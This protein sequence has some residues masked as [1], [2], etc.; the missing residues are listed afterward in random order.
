MMEANIPPMCVS[1]SLEPD[2][3]KWYT[4]IEQPSPTIGLVGCNDYHR[5]VIQVLEKCRKQNQGDLAVNFYPLDH[6]DLIRKKREN[7]GPVE[8]SAP[9]GLLKS[10]WCKR[11]QT[12]IFGC[13]IV[14][15]KIDDFSSRE[16]FETG[17]EAIISKVQYRLRGR[18]TKLLVVIIT[19]KDRPPFYERPESCP[20][21]I[22]KRCD[23]EA[24][25]NVTL[26]YLGGKNTSDPIKKILQTAQDFSL[27]Y[28]KEECRRIKRFKETAHKKLQPR[29]RFK[30]A[31]HME[32]QR[33]VDLSLKYYSQAY[34]YV[35]F[36]SADKTSVS[37]I[38]AASEMIMFRIC[39]TRLLYD[40]VPKMVTAIKIFR[41]HMNWYKTCSELTMRAVTSGGSRSRFSDSAASPK[42]SS[43]R[44]PLSPQHSD[45]REE[46]SSTGRSSHLA[47]TIGI[48][49]SVVSGEPASPT[50][51]QLPSKSPTAQLLHYIAIARQNDQFA[52]LLERKAARGTQQSTSDGSEYSNPGYY[53]QSAAFAIEDRRNHVA[54]LIAIHGDPEPCDEKPVSRDSFVGQTWGGEPTELAYLAKLLQY[55][56]TISYENEI[57]AVCGKAKQAF[58]RRGLKRVSQTISLLM[59]R[60]CM[61]LRQYDEA[62]KQL[63]EVLNGIK[64]C[65]FGQYFDSALQLKMELAKASNQTQDYIQTALLYLSN[66][67][68]VDTPNNTPEVRQ[69]LLANMISQKEYTEGSVPIPWNHRMLKTEVRFNKPSVSVHTE[70]EIA[71]K[72]STCCSFPIYIHSISLSFNQEEVDFDYKINKS[73]QKKSDISIQVP[74]TFT[75]PGIVQLRAV[76]AHIGIESEPN[77]IC[78]IQE[79]SPCVELLSRIISNRESYPHYEEVTFPTLSGM[80]CKPTRTAISV[81]KPPP[82]VQLLLEHQYVF[83]YFIFYVFC[84]L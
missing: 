22:R 36:L 81:Q 59:A 45:T 48:P 53:L 76:I 62:D 66:Y 26:C 12:E 23:I 30:I 21:A 20:S 50:V 29:H 39:L 69:S 6:P 33:Q 80:T 64:E 14:L 51:Q 3:F 32:T 13:V 4:S 84:I 44:A 34:E 77:T 28:Y 10:D 35:R 40:E 18:L 27:S 24:A 2:G 15:I 17:S 83:L 7:T 43:F 47:S 38:K 52:W 1:S 75:F 55:E 58:H 68:V 60:C 63:Q 82:N 74:K 61:A 73:I 19:T 79:A 78:L 9:E 70:C 46:G 65:P 49:S 11:H 5:D 31:Y 71:V 42:L 37:E 8:H 67:N 56:K 16:S 41:E 57:L 25:K 72:L 54:T